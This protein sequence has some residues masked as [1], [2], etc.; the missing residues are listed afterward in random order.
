MVRSGEEMEREREREEG[1]R[2]QQRRWRDFI[3]WPLASDINGELEAELD[4]LE[5]TTRPSELNFR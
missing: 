1:G 2:D 4:D 5:S 3:V